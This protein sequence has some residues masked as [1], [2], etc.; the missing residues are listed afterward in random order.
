MFSLRIFYVFLKAT[1]YG[2]I[3]C[4]NRG[5]EH[6]LDNVGFTPKSIFNAKKL[7]FHSFWNPN[8]HMHVRLCIRMHTQ[9]LSMR[10]HTCVCVRMPQGFLCLYFSK[11]AHPIHNKSYIFPKTVSSSQFQSDWALNQLWVLEFQHHWGTGARVEK[12]TKCGVY[13]IS[14]SLSFISF[15]TLSLI[16]V[17]YKF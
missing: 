14:N 8:M 4:E 11:I 6:L 5:L 15:F 16:P 7:V 17:P 9:S 3:Q 2:F 10:A 13:T 1:M 12:G